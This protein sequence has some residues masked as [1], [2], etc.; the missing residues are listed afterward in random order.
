MVRG[1]PMPRANSGVAAAALTN[2]PID[3]AATASRIKMRIN[4]P[5]LKERGNYMNSV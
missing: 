1:I 3:K 2:I 5:S 4:M